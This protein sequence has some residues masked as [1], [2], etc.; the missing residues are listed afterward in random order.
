MKPEEVTLD[1]A[2]RYGLDIAQPRHGYRFSLDALL[3]SDFSE[4][5]DNAR[6]IDLGTGCGIIPL[7]LCRRFPAATA[8]GIERNTE[9]AALAEANT[10]RN[11]LADRITIVTGD[12]NDSK[13][14][15]PV[16]SFDGVTCNPP[17]RSAKTGRV[18]PKS[19]RDSARHE[20]SAGLADFLA[21]AK[22]LVK[23]S[24]RICFVYHPDRLAEFIHC[25]TTLNLALLRLRLVHGTA[26]APAT[27]FLAELA[28]GRKGATSVLPPLVIY[29]ADEAYTP[30]ARLILGEDV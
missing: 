27:I 12:I 8:V 11:S 7:V 6:I 16:S 23:P 28:K 26:T 3:L 4:P 10:R 20:T 5:A 13:T 9:M 17:F 25:A 22:F 29:G 24:G 30:E 14:L 15:F 1:Q 2:R 18:S 19:G 21:A